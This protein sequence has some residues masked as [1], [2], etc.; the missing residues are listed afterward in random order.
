[1]PRWFTVQLIAVVLNVRKRYV[2]AQVKHVGYI[3]EFQAQLMYNIVYFSPE[4]NSLRT[5]LRSRVNIV[6]SHLAAS[7]LIPVGSLFLEEVFP[8]LFSQ[9]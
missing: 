3:M 4:T 7:S 1:M 6:A 2:S 8:F 9:L 5:P